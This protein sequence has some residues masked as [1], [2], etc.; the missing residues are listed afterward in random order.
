MAINTQKVVVGGL[1][2]GVVLAALDA[3]VNG[4]LL[5]DQN[6]A[7]MNALN[8][9][10]MENMESPGAIVA[11]VVIDFL[12]AILLTWTYAAM[13]PRF[14]PGPKTA[15]VAGLQVWL[16][17]ILLYAFMTAAGM[18]AWGYFAVGAA[19]SFV[20]FQVAAQIGGKIYS[21]EGS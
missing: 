5:A 1:A 3:V 14:G 6:E 21:E 9:A 19:T 15:F 8:P 10:L 12:F 7:A 18:Y 2:A 4:F 17:A 20:L 16:V 11:V 13:R